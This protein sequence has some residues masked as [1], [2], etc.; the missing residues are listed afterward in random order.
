M[1]P[2]MTDLARECAAL[3]AMSLFIASLGVLMLAL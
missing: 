1:E 3:A 2:C